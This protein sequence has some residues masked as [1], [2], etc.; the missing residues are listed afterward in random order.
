VFPYVVTE[1]EGHTEQL[2]VTPVAIGLNAFA[3]H[4][5]EYEHVFAPL[6]TVHDVVLSP[7]IHALQSHSQEFVVAAP[8]HTALSGRPVHGEQLMLGSVVAMSWLAL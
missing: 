8:V 1:L 5:P 6:V 4:V 3:S 2:I 7:A